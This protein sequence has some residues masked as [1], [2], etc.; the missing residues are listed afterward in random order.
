MLSPPL[1]AGSRLLLVTFLTLV[2]KG[3][4]QEPLLSRVVL[5]P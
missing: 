5:G 4:D 2:Q 3:L 1:A